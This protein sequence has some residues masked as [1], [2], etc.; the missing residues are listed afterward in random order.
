M[1]KDLK[2]LLYVFGVYAREIVIPREDAKKAA[3]KA[4]KQKASGT[5]TSQSSSSGSS[6]N[7]SGSKTGTGSKSGSSSGKTTK[8]K[9][10]P[11][12]LDIEGYYEDYK[13]YDAIIGATKEVA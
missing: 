5:G 11:D 6:Q 8:K 7:G 1:S 3:E 4:A 9:I 12:D 2:E 13:D 10:D